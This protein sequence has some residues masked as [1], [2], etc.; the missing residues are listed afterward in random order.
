MKS[1]CVAHPPQ[2]NF[3]VIR[4]WALQFCDG[5]ATAAALLSIFEN[6]HNGKLQS[7]DQRRIKDPDDQ[8]YLHPDGS[9]VDT[10]LLQWHTEKQLLE[11]VR[12]VCKTRGTL[13][14]AIEL[15]IRKNAISV[16]AN[17]HPKYSY[18]NSKHYLFYPQ[19]IN[20]WIGDVF[21]STLTNI[22]QPLTNISQP[23]TNIDHTSPYKLKTNNIDSFSNEKEFTSLFSEPKREPLL[24][25]LLGNL[26]ELE[27]H[28]R[29]ADY[30]AEQLEFI[31]KVEQAS[32]NRAG[33]KKNIKFEIALLEKPIAYRVYARAVKLNG[34]YK[35]E[36]HTNGGPD[37]L[38]ELV[39]DAPSDLTLL[40]KIVSTACDLD[41]WQFRRLDLVMKYFER[42]EIPGLKNGE[43]HGQ[44]AIDRSKQPTNGV[45]SQHEREKAPGIPDEVAAILRKREQ[46]A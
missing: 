7:R 12:G 41:L 10:F 13:R 16:H 19:N 1:T 22:S 17:P 44:R 35:R 42:R 6:Y 8:N 21:T 32:K 23:L 40:E 37:R 39:G 3:V 43:N 24:F 45:T 5:N 18:D 26:D 9:G 34:K 14:S 25:A 11:K 46:E 2:H 15:L 27:T 4:D 20:A 33:A 36:M 31:L 30:N 38:G 29:E 28:L